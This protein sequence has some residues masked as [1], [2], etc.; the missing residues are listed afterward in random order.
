MR[1][2]VVP[3][4]PTWSDKYARESARVASALGSCVVAIHHVGS[5]AIP[6]IHAK[7]VVDMLAEVGSLPEVD[8]RT[9]AMRELGYEAMGECGIPGRR[10]FRKDDDRGFREYHVHAFRA[11]SPGIVRHLAFRDFLIAHPDLARR[12]SDLKRRLAVE[13]PD[14]IEGYMD[15]KNAFIQETERRAIRWW[16]PSG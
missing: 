16:K 9:A 8:A 11:G 1:V 5:T 10:Y 3:H 12:Y 15:G 13:H 4:D 14:D 6:T 7:P 2:V